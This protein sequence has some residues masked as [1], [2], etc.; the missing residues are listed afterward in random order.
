VRLTRLG[1]FEEL[2]SCLGVQGLE[3]A[4]LYAL[5][6]GALFLYRSMYSEH[7]AKWLKARPSSPLTPP[8]PF[9]PPLLPLPRLAATACGAAHGSRCA[10]ALTPGP[11]MPSARTLAGRCTRRSSCW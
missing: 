8:S 4:K 9:G 11:H 6:E 3:Q 10:P 2:G 5:M 7:L 1:A